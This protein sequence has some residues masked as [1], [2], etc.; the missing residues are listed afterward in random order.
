MSTARQTY[1]DESLKETRDALVLTHLK[2]VRRILD[3]LA[4]DLP[5]GVDIDNLESAGILGLM[6]A[7]SQYDATRNIPFVAF[8]RKRIRGEILDE[9]RRNSPLPQRVLANIATVRRSME[10]LGFDASL[11]EIA[12]DAGLT[13]QEIEETLL[14]MR[15]AS[16]RSYE[17]SDF[18]MHGVRDNRSVQ[19]DQALEYDEIRGSLADAIESLPRNE[20]LVVSLYYFENCTLKEIGKS[21]NLSESRIS[22]LLTKAEERLHRAVQKKTR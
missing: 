21:M 17:E 6:Q 22:R 1:R 3:R 9:L 4:C 12:A 14:S 20:R 13:E 11:E 2:L 10:R 19:P 18:L 7:A 5:S 15:V 8:A 16:A